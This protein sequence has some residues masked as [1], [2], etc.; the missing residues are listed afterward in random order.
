MTGTEL[1]KVGR[2]YAALQTYEARQV[3]RRAKDDAIEVWQ[4]WCFRFRFRLVSSW[5]FSALAW[6][7][8]LRVP[9]HKSFGKFGS[10]EVDHEPLTYGAEI[11]RATA[12]FGGNEKMSA[13]AKRPDTDDK[14]RFENGCKTTEGATSVM[15]YGHESGLSLVEFLIFERADAYMRQQR[16]DLQVMRAKVRLEDATGVLKARE[17]QRMERWKT[18]L[19]VSAG[20]AGVV[21][22]LISVAVL[23]FAS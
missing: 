14:C 9:K 7:L 15:D 22:F 2:R 11:I 5:P 23:F 20:A 18:V 6:L 8:R 19:A 10:N 16:E 12:E 13:L 4:Y 17:V 1:L 3:W 21:G